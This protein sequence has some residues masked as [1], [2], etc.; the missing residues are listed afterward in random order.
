MTATSFDMW[1]DTSAINFI[2]NYIS[3]KETMTYGILD[4]AMEDTANDGD[5]ADASVCGRS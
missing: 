3:Q 5:K 4:M 1:Q 2:G